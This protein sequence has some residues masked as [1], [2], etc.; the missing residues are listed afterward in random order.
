[1]G[2]IVDTST[3]IGMERRGTPPDALLDV[4]ID[5]PLA[6]ASITLSE[7]MVG[8]LRA[9]SLARR[10]SRER[11]LDRTLTL[12]KVLPFDADR[13]RIHAVVVTS[14]TAQG[15]FINTHDMLIA[16][17]ALS[18]GYGVLTHNVRDF[19]RVPGLVVRQPNW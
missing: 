17:T 12:L 1:M 8:M 5:E 19:G 3:L 6:M 7:L 14:L 9:N 15:Q 16:A 18:L 2:V 13:A 11:F 10:V 4:V